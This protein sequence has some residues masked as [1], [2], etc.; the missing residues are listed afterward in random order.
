MGFS[1]GQSDWQIKAGATKSIR[2][3]FLIDAEVLNNSA[4]DDH[5][6]TVLAENSITSLVGGYDYHDYYNAEGYGLFSELDLVK[7]ISIGGSYNYTL[8]SSLI[9][10]TGYSFFDGVILKA[11]I[12][13]LMLTLVL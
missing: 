13:Q 4:T 3:S 8:Y 5:W 6:R 9:N 1:T 12:L 7:F 11:S 2:N 10:N